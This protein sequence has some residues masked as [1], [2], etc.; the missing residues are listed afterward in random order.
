MQ[1]NIKLVSQKQC[2]NIFDAMI[3]FQ[4]IIFYNFM[5]SVFI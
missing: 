5:T 1:W 3:F 4:E 2:L